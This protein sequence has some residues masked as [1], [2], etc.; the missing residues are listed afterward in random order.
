MNSLS[1]QESHTLE[2]LKKDN[3]RG[4]TKDNVADLVS[5]FEKLDPEVA[6]SL[7]EQL[8]EAVKGMV[9]IERFYSELLTKGIDSCYSTA[10]SCFNTEDRIVE[11][12]AEETKKDIPFEQKQYYVDQMVG[13]AV[14]K[15]KKDTEHRDTLDKIFKYGGMALA[16]GAGVALTLF[17]GGRGGGSS[18]NYR[19]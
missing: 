19:L 10:N 11:V 14:R 4:V 3:F 7:I 2:R 8:P 5:I 9:E 18:S 17:L 12:L 13:A 15:E 6:K 1:P 16:F